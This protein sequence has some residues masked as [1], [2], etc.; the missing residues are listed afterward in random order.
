LRFKGTAT[1]S[2]LLDG[3]DSTSFV[4]NDMLLETMLELTISGDLDVAGDTTVADFAVG[5]SSTVTMGGAVIQNVGTPVA[6]TDAA[7]KA[8]VDAVSSGSTSGLALKVDIAGDTMTG[9]LILSGSPTIGLH[10]TTKD[11][12]DT[13]ITSGVSSGITGKVD[14][15]GDTMTG[16]LILD[17]DPTI[18]LGAATK[19]YVDT[20]VASATPASTSNA[21]GTRTVSTSPPVG[22]GSN[23][24]IHY[25]I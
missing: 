15:A 2:E 6:S 20:T 14:I 9:S 18:A 5:T 7:T 16:S 25:Q 3:I 21:F 13:S 8:D 12:V 1:D 17:A 11:Y 23:G 24:D 19:D 22:T 4:R 10:A